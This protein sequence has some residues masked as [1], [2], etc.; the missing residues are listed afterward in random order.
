MKQFWKYVLATVVGI[1]V[2]SAVC[3]LF[4]LITLGAIVASGESKPNVKEGSVLHL[5][6]S[7]IIEER[8]TSNP[9]AEVLGNNAV[10]KQGLDDLLKAIKEAKTNKDISGIYIEGGALSADVATLQELRKALVDFKTSKKFVLAYAD[11][12][13]QG[14][15]YLASTADKVLVNP[16]GMIDW[17]GL[18]SQPIFYTDLLKKVGVKMQVFKVGTYKSAVEPFILTEMSDAN[19]EQLSACLG[20]L[21]GNIAKD[22]SASRGVSV[23]S[24][25][26]L[27]DKYMVFAE[28]KD[29]ISAH[30]ADQLCYA[31]EVRDLLRKYS[32]T[33][34]VN[35][36]E[37]SELVKIVEEETS[38][39]K[40]AVY[41][42]EGD[43]V[44]EP[45]TT[46]LAQNTPQIVGQK[47]VEDLDKLANDDDVKA[48]VIRV[49]SGGGS[50]Y[51]SEQ[52]W[53]AVEL[54]KKKKPV[55]VS[56][57]GLAASGGYYMSCGA[58][59]IVAEPT[60]LTGSIGIF[61]M[62][63][64]LSGLL[65]EKLGLHFDEVKTNKSAALGSMARP[66]N[67]DES[68]A[69]QAHVNRGY[70]QFISRVAAGRNLT[71]EQVDKIGQGR[72]WTGEQALTIK[73][74]DKLGTL[75]DAVAEAAKRAKLTKY[76]VTSAP[77]KASWIDQVL[78]STVK[79][80]YMEERL[81]TVLGEYYAPLRFVRSLNGLDPKSYVQARMYFVPNFK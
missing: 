1:V 8:S 48:V 36:I 60:T 34:K 14:T 46:N 78:D 54:L 72:V 81:Q 4:G 76:C 29:Y 42:A 19:R 79:R 55:V 17:K 40:V 26:A 70:K 31:D 74:V 43:I 71:T 69:L 22:V 59:Y 45:A 9:F 12:Y 52:M 10:K 24:L 6:L 41:Y 44:D 65:T 21:W 37:P 77:D 63:P 33:E 7:G 49:N 58:D 27:A 50:A 73:L 39:D 64:D 47:V 28:S 2:V 3:A 18:A 15:Y 5:D 68:A 16:D 38:G 32:K 53:R 13:T 67:A 51:A 62:V 30:L 57:G 20:S 23:D 80:D 11:V 66:F 75:N 25:N 56:M 61:G 35:L